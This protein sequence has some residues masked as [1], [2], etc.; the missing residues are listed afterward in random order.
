MLLSRIAVGAFGALFVVIGFGAFTSSPALAEGK[1]KADPNKGAQI[2]QQVCVA[3]H[4]NDGNGTAPANPKLAGQHHE[5]LVKQL[6]NFKPKSAGN[7]AARA[8]PIMTGFVATLS[9]EDIENL[10]AYYSAQTLKPAVAKVKDS[11]EL[12]QKI[13]RSGIA[14]KGVPACAGCHGPTGAGIPAQYPRLAGQYAE[15]TESQLVAFRQGQRKNNA[16]MSAISEV[17][18][19]REIKAVADYIAGLR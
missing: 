13:F 1:V 2:V 6:Y 10:A 4:G 5:Y 12:G 11:V 17:L 7:E 18:S 8:N 15:Y 9:D 16:Q 3:C 19:D 14:D